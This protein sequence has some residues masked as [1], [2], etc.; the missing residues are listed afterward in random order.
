MKV[1]S[2]IWT[3]S[4]R[5]LSQERE[6]YLTVHAGRAGRSVGESL[7]LRI[8]GGKVILCITYADNRICSV[9]SFAWNSRCGLPEEYL[10]YP[11]RL[12]NGEAGAW[13]VSF[14]YQEKE[15]IVS[16]FGDRDGGELEKEGVLRLYG[17]DIL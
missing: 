12:E 9:K 5:S 17:P 1:S 4:E 11:V 16:A 8:R 13:R 15:D 2:G 10:M 14:T 3:N 6:K 7:Y